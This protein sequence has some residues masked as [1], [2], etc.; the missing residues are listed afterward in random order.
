M[1]ED[2]VGVNAAV[3]AAE[4]GSDFE[5]EVECSGGGRAG[6]VGGEA[7]FSAGDT[8]DGNFWPARPPLDTGLMVTE[9]VSPLACAAPAGFSSQ[10]PPAL[11]VSTPL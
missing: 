1:G 3:A 4:G 6:G 10:F 8:L 2:G 5:V 11:M 7:D 9:E